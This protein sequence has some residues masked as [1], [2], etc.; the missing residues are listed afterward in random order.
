M[1]E[2]SWPAFMLNHPCTFITSRLRYAP[3]LH[4]VDALYHF[5]VYAECM[6]YGDY[7]EAANSPAM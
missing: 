1:D 3:G 4:C 2:Q 6:F 5:D 7:M